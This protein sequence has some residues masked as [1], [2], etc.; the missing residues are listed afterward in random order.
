ML[1]RPP[2]ENFEI[3][4]KDATLCALFYTPSLAITL[5]KLSCA[6]DRVPRTSPSPQ[7]HDSSVEEFEAA[8]TKARISCG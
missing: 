2:F 8:L 7:L 6:S 4:W 5:A 3:S 1:S